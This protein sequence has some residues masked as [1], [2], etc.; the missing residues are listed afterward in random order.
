MQRP[1]KRICSQG[2]AAIQGLLQQIDPQGANSRILA[3]G[4][5]FLTANCYRC[6]FKAEIVQAFGPCPPLIQ[7]KVKKRHL[8]A[9]KADFF[10]LF[11]NRQ[12]V[13][14]HIVGPEKQIHAVFHF[15][16][17]FITNFSEDCLRLLG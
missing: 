16:A 2:L 7:V 15:D 5:G 9:V 8:N 3:D 13:I 1:V 17:P 14:M 6:P 10:Y 12:H 11:Q 4:I